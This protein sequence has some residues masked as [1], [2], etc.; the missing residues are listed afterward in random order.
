MRASALDEVRLRGPQLVLGRRAVDSRED[1][2]LRDGL[3]GCDVD[4]GEDAA[5]G[6]VQR[7]VLGSDRV[8]RR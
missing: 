1:L 7:E 4:L 8:A 3:P 2:A 5:A 6:E